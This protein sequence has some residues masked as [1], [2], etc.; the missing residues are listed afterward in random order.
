LH[1][2]PIA[3]ASAPISPP[4]IDTELFELNQAI[5]HV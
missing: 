3:L 2:L 1:D 4:A 5:W